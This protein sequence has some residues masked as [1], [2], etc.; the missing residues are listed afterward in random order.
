MS[1]QTVRECIIVT[2]LACIVC[3]PCSEVKGHF[4]LFTRSYLVFLSISGLTFS[5]SLAT[6]T[7]LTF[8]WILVFAMQGL[9]KTVQAIGIALCF[10]EDWPLLIICPKSLRLQWLQVYMHN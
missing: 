10:Q 1:T 8:A 7:P 6:E 2:T 5:A 3:R 4:I 9:G